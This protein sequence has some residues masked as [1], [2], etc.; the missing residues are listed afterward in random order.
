MASFLDHSTNP[1]NK[2]SVYQCGSTHDLE[3]V[4]TSL[5]E[6]STFQFLTG[7]FA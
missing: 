7:N 1:D 6:K 2:T 3:L 5:A 4:G